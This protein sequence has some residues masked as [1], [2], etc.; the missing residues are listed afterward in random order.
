MVSWW[1]FGVKLYSTIYRHIH[2]VHWQM[3]QDLGLSGSHSFTFSSLHKI[4]NIG[5]YTYMCNTSHSEKDSGKP[6]KLWTSFL[7]FFTSGAHVLLNRVAKLGLLGAFD[8]PGR[9]GV[10]DGA[11]KQSWKIEG[12][13]PRQVKSIS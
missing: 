5:E 12:F 10:D 11:V 1:H 6:I 13:P 8:D 4:L 3:N 2:N 9:L 7:P